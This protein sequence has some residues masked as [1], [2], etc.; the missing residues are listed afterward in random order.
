M[1]DRRGGWNGKR[2]GRD[3]KD[4]LQGY[5]A[6][7]SVL[8]RKLRRDLVSLWVYKGSLPEQ[9]YWSF[10]SD[11]EERVTSKSRVRVKGRISLAEALEKDT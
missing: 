4:K 5:G 6:Q 2:E 8:Q 1:D 11:P 7:Y 3:R 10:N 9:E